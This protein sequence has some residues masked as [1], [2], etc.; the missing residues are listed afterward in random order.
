MSYTYAEKK[1]P[2]GA[3]QRSPSVPAASPEALRAGAVQPTPELLG[4]PVDLPGA[5]RAKM[6][7]SFGADLSAVRLY[8]SQAVAD[9]GANA[10]AQG[11]RIAFAPGRLDFAS[12]SGQTLLGHELSQVVSQARGE[13]SG[14]GFLRDAALEARADREG[15]MA[16]AG[17]QVYTGP[18]TAALSSAS[19][20]TGPMQASKAAGKGARHYYSMIRDLAVVN[21]K[22]RSAADREKYQKKAA[23]HEKWMRFWARRLNPKA[24][25]KERDAAASDS[26]T[27]HYNL[28]DK[29]AASRY[30]RINFLSGAKD[31]LADHEKRRQD[32]KDKKP[33]SPREDSFGLNSDAWKNWEDWKLNW[34][35]AS[36]F[37]WGVP[38]KGD[39]FHW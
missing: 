32:A 24:I 27:F 21:D 38:Y 13:V 5:I 1:H 37:D 15:A 30:A 8:E 9:A 28:T 14:S 23:S 17:E 12:A 16:A 31:Y 29:Q 35:G 36:I 4:Q 33:V 7:A 19:A 6:E 20:A 2:V 39:F 3:P 18:V 25:D 26:I 10:V 22:S 11:S 34:D